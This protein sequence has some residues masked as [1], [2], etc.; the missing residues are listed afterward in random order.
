MDGF[1]PR[2]SR[3][4]NLQLDNKKTPMISINARKKIKWVLFNLAMKE[5]VLI[6][7]VAKTKKKKFLGSDI[8]MI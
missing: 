8:H 6:F 5:Q 3:K 2:S 7:Q 4:Q 1:A